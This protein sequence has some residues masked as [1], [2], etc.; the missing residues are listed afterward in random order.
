MAS[1]PALDQADN[2]PNPIPVPLD[3]ATPHPAAAGLQSRAAAAEDDTLATVSDASPPTPVT[4][5]TRWLW[6]L[7]GLG[8]L[9]AVFYLGGW[10]TNRSIKPPIVG[11]FT[12]NATPHSAPAVIVHVTGAVAH[13]GVY[14][15]PFDARITDAIHEAGGALPNADTNA[16]NLAAW[17][18][19]G[20]R[21]EVPVKAAPAAVAPAVATPHQLP[22]QPAARERPAPALAPPAPLPA[23][24]VSRSK[25]KATRTAR[26]KDGSV[27]PHATTPSGKT[28]KKI[29]PAYLAQHPINVNTAPATDLQELPGIGPAMAAKI[30]TYRQENG[31]FQDADDLRNVKG[32]G[33]KKLAKL[34]PLVTV[35]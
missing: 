15:L 34:Q 33:E 8:I 5:M 21:I 32:I 11:P 24:R 22:S 14:H 28:S 17:V 7:L 30:I 23:V 4:T 20:T 27:V 13:P 26:V 2:S 6:S 31:R 9:Y 10:A 25:P 3:K 12:T 16:L 29:D 19:D 1:D 18:E 35:K